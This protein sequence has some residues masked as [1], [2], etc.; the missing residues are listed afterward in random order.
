MGRAGKIFLYIIYFALVIVLAGFITHSL[1]SNKTTP[2]KP[3]ASHHATVA[4]PKAAPQTPVPSPS[5]SS[6]SNPALA[7]SG[8]G[9]VLAIFFGASL[10]STLAYRQLLLSRLKNQQT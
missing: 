1:T 7:N 6:P 2:S 9:D 8:P 3:P 10:I 4:T 5:P